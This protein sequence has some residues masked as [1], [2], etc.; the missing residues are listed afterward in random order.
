M[1][2][3]P[4]DILQ[5]LVTKN[6]RLV[7]GVM[8]GTSVDAVDVALV[9]LRGGG[10]GTA[11]HL[12]HAH[13]TLFPEE[14]Q[15]MIFANSEPSRSTVSD[16]CVLHSALA[17]L[18]ADAIRE[19]C[20]AAGI[21]L[22]DIDLV[23]LHGQTIHHMP[24]PTQAGPYDVRSSLQIGSGPTLAALLGVP[25]VSDFRAPDLALGGQ[26][27]PL[28]PYVDWLLFRHDTEHRIMLNI[29]GI[30]NLAWLPACC[31]DDDVLAFDT[32]PGNMIVDALMRVLYGREFD[33]GGRVAQSG[34]VAPDLLDWM[35][36]HPYFR[37]PYPKSAGR[38]LFG[39]AYTQQYLQIAR[40]LSVAAP[41]DLVATAAECT[42]R[43][44]AAG[45]QSL[46][47]ADAPAALYLMGGG[48]KN[49][50]FRNALRFALP[51]AR[52]ADVQE[53]GINADAK[54]AVCFAVLANEWLQGNAANLPRVTGAR[55]KIL[56]G[57]FAAG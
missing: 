13:E 50:F 11:L 24:E 36:R 22:A 48:A 19:A 28:V 55:R 46:V 52:V 4:L 21:A 54:E 16:I 23:G 18:Y 31:R 38:E 2:R 33:D 42:V 27:A 5:R 44:I 25:V 43:A 15:D 6:E 9:R 40:E 3:S 53:L 8:S 41:A 51:A 30:A 17:H 57:S 49:L 20:G 1:T 12:V 10:P 34:R 32:G 56:L 45:V 39:T 35:L 29:G 26:G 37:Q 47:P 14:L 7:C